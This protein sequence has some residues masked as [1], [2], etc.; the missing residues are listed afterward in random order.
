MDKPT[1][2]VG[3]LVMVAEPYARPADRG[4]VYRVTDIHKVNIVAR[5]V[6]GGPGVKGRPD[7]FV[8]APPDATAA[9][10]TI[11]YQP[12]LPPG[13]VVTVAGPGWRQPAGEFYVV[14][15]QRPD[16]KV[17]VARLGGDPKGRY[18]PSVPRTM[19]TPVDPARITIGPPP[20]GDTDRGSANTVT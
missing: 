17:S 2:V 9:A 19:L 11:E 1:F 5:P 18:W 12:P 7:I 20:D 13:Q 4:V 8:P 6:T 16:T 10:A 3:D 15:R 14:L